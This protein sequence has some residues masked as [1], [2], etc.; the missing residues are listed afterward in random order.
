MPAAAV[1]DQ[2]VKGI[3][4]ERYSAYFVSD[5]DPGPPWLA[6]SGGTAL[7]TTDAAWL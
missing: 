3:F 2:R 7:P 1:E 6:A 4:W 5:V